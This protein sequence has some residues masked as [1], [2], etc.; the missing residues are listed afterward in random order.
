MGWYN[1]QPDNTD[2][3]LSPWSPI[4]SPWSPIP[5]PWSPI[6][7]PSNQEMNS[8][9]TSIADLQKKLSTNSFYGHE[10]M[11]LYYDC[12]SKKANGWD[13]RICRELDFVF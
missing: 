13:N 12:F 6:P 2:L 5:S 4:P 9:V 10:K 11:Q 1:H 7:D 8:V 3:D